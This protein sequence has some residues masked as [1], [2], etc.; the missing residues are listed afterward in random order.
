[1]KVFKFILLI[2]IF[3]MA[4]ELA[5]ATWEECDTADS[6]VSTGVA[7]DAN[8]DGQTNVVDLLVTINFVLGTGSI[9]YYG[10]HCADLNNDDIINILDII[11]LVNIILGN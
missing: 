11:L 1:M 6:T 9:D 5:V 3:L 8:Q 10:F 2:L 4:S 7:G